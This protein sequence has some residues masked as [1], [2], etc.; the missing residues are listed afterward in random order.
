ML[1]VDGKS[2]D[3]KPSRAPSIS[4]RNSMRDTKTGT[5][6]SPVLHCV[7]YILR[8]CWSIEHK[9]SRGQSVVLTNSMENNQYNTWATAT[10]RKHLK[11]CFF[12]SENDHGDH[13]P[14]TSVIQ[15]WETTGGW[16]PS[17][18]HIQITAILSQLGP[19]IFQCSS[20][21]NTSQP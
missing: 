10:P 21:L 18:C 9:P 20:F 4:P 5:S 19:K 14:D 12:L 2:T 16:P 11:V 3:H 15:C 7:M 8:R 6:H 17:P 13:H 1:Y